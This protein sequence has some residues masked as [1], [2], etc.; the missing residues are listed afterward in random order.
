ML[1][2]ADLLWSMTYMRKKER[3]VTNTSAKVLQFVLLNAMLNQL[4]VVCGNSSQAR[5]TVAT[6]ILIYHCKYSLVKLRTS[7][8]HGCL[9][10][11]S[12]GAAV[13]CFLVPVYTWAV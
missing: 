8:L 10:A 3:I 1:F 7:V 13:L 11:V 2:L 9:C 6:N 5:L 12:C 4:A